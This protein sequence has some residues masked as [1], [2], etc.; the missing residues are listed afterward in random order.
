MT[1]NLCIGSTCSIN[2]H[3]E[4]KFQKILLTKS[5]DSRQKKFVVSQ[6]RLFR[7]V[8]SIDLSEVLFIECTTVKSRVIH[9]WSDAY[10][11]IAVT[12]N[13][14][15]R[16]VNDKRQRYSMKNGGSV[17]QL[18]YSSLVKTARR[19]CLCW[20]KKH[21]MSIYAWDAIHSVLF[22]NAR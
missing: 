19:R 17:Q 16:R 13:T 3:C 10:A 12:L 15:W 1:I 7:Y 14:K 4:R 9:Y 6:S 22:I 5:K 21:F 11:S 18:S 20:R 8:Q 2:F